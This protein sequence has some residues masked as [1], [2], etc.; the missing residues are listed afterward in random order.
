[1][2]IFSSSYFNIRYSAKYVPGPTLR[3]CTC[4][5]CGYCIYKSLH[6]VTTIKRKGILSTL[7]KE[8]IVPGKNRKYIF[9]FIINHAKRIKHTIK[10]GDVDLNTWWYKHCVV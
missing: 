9:L 1:M 4:V 2:K 10:A 7:H 6:V 8:N 5:N 3:R